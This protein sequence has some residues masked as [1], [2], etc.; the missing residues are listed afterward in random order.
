MNN[1]TRCTTHMST[2]EVVTPSER[3][4]SV[5]HGCA[6]AGVYG[7]VIRAS[8]DIQVEVKRS[9]M[10]RDDSIEGERLSALVPGQSMVRADENDQCDE[11]AIKNVPEVPKI[12]HHYQTNMQIDRTN[13]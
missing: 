1:P 10:Y 9:R 13:P 5:T 7:E 8:Q 12:L 2:W 4:G 6:D 3:N 11:T